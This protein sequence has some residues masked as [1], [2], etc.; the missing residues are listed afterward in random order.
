MEAS[1]KTL[2]TV[3]ANAFDTDTIEFGCRQNGCEAGNTHDGDV[4][5]RWSCK[6]D[7]LDGTDCEITYAF[8]EPQ[9]IARML[10]A[11]FKGDERTRVLEVMVNDAF[12]SVIESSGQTDGFEEFELNTYGTKTL[13]LKSLGLRREKWIS[14]SE[15]SQG[16]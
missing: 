14:I 9:N 11:F 4:F 3:T 7:L 5:T 15:V 6:S 16:L 12:H 10:I 1:E 13:T 8:D 2:V